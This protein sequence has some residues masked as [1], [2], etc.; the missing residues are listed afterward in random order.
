MSALVIFRDFDP[1]YK[2]PFYDVSWSEYNKIGYVTGSGRVVYPL[3]WG[4]SK[5]SLQKIERKHHKLVP[6]V[7]MASLDNIEIFFTQNRP[8]YELFFQGIDA[9]VRKDNAFFNS[10]IKLPILCKISNEEFENKWNRLMLLLRPTDIIMVFDTTSIVSKAIVFI[11]GGV[12]SHTAGYV[13]DEQIIESTVSGVIERSISVYRSR[14][15]RIG[16]YRV[17]DYEGEEEKNAKWIAYLRSQIG[18]S[19]SYHDAFTVGMNKIMRRRPQ[20]SNP[21][22]TS[23]NDLAI[24]PNLNL[25][26]SI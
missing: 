3:L 9:I 4:L 24:N 12:W 26:L 16:L 25:I 13:G 8:N 5:T 19:Y 22:F 23:P 6:L 20:L 15:Y 2:R 18:K 10:P 17:K 11:D 21:R 14:Q 7:F 1:W